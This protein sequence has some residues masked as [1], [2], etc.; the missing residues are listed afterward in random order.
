MK[1]YL[2]LLSYARPLG[3]S[4]SQYIVFAL[5]AIVFGLLNISLLIPLLEVLFGTVDQAADTPISNPEFSFTINYIKEKFNYYFLS[6]VN[7][8]GKIA[9]L[10]F[11]CIMILATNLLKGFFRYF[12]TR[13]MVFI[14]ARLIMNLRSA[15][16][17][18]LSDM[19]TG[20]FSEHKKGDL[21][22]RMTSDIQEVE[23]SIVNTIAVVFREP[24]TLIG[25]FFLLFLMSA[26][27]TFFTILVLPTAGFA[28][29]K[30]LR[31]LKKQAAE[32]QV[33]LGN[34]VS[35]IDEA[36]GSIKVI[37]GFNAENYIN[38]KFEVHNQAYSSTLRSMSLK[39]DLASPLTEFFG[40]GLVA[41]ILYY[42]GTLVLNQ[43]AD[44]KASEFITYIVLLS[45]VMA[46][47]R[48]I[49]SAVTAIQRG[50]EAGKRVLSIIDTKPEIVDSPNAVSVEKFEK[51]IDFK[52][53]F[54][55]YD[56][57]KDVLKNINFELKRGKT[58]AL[59][60]PS[61]GGK[62]T[63]AD[64]LPRFYDPT[65]GRIEID[66]KAL[67]EVK[68]KSIRAQMGIVTQESMLFNDSIANNIAFTK[69][70]ATR[71]EIIDAAKIANAHDFIMQAEKGYDTVI[72]DRGLKLSGGQRQRI[73][74]ARAVLKN[75]DILILDEATSALDTES[76]KLVQEALTNLLKNR[77]SLI[78]AHR[79]STIQHADEILVIKDGEIVE[80]GNHLKLMQLKD[81]VYRK[82]NELQS[83]I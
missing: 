5:L 66:G 53:V 64:L 3:L 82:L 22:S 41:G 74:I 17:N 55:S 2:R 12:A 11:V 30:L 56:G 32:V 72:G 8:Y 23:N 42:G 20:F 73:S 76:E 44:L 81:G 50:L 47:M 6:T 59:V 14:R 58:V 31:K 69:T 83:T 77:T 40:V 52:G 79:L 27:L 80:R 61:G 18:R 7:E 75:P 15:I 71:E 36:L 35:T 19:H 54:F 48:L 60:G 33:I 46:P 25:F 16:F 49:S 4:L 10:E 51:G 39:R 24:A 68:I 29:S 70:E 9:A 43:E 65:K 1:I 26:K 37:R 63:I 78:I 45:Q 21:T 67:N 38:K 28:F 13:V 62:S 34:M 57:E